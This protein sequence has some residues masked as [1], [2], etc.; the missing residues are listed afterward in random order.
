MM[1][2]LQG[3]QEVPESVSHVFTTRHIEVCPGMV[4]GA[5]GMEEHQ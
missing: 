4:I 2:D 1:H 5:T 3:R